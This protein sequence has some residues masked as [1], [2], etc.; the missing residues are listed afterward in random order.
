MNILLLFVG[1]SLITVGFG[2]LF[3]FLAR[4]R[5]ALEQLFEYEHEHLPEQWIKDGCPPGRPKR[6]SDDKPISL[7]HIFSP[8][9]PL[10]FF[11][12]IFTTPEWVKQNPEAMSYLHRFR[13][14]VF[15]WNIG[16]P[17]WLLLFILCYTGVMA[18][19]LR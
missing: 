5:A 12:Y 7:L 2:L 3:L 18:L 4:A 17:V 11:L 13:R 16:V 10:I 1:G 8:Y 19:T 15:Y 9:S 14:Y 6:N